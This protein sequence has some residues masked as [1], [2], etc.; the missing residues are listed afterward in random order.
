MCLLQLSLLYKPYA[1]PDSWHFFQLN[2][3]LHWYFALFL[4]Q[5]LLSLSHSL[6]RGQRR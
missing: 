3:I 2:V 6:H 4:D 1:A 5:L